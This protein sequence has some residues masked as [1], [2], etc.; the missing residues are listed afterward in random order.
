MSPSSSSANAAGASSGGGLNNSHS[1]CELTTS[2]A[3]HI[4]L[5]DSPNKLVYQ[6]MERIVKK[7][8]KEES[9]KKKIDTKICINRDD[10]TLKYKYTVV[11]IDFGNR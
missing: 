6:R 11:G 5:D 1:C 7:M 8:Q 9:G 3:L 4:N 2:K 10:G